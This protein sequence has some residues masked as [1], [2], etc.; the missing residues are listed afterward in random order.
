VSACC[1]VGWLVGW[2]FVV[3]LDGCL[4]SG[5]VNVCCL[6]GWVSVC[7]LSG[8]VF[9]CMG[10]CFTCLDRWVF[11]WLSGCLFG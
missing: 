2:A 4:L 5:W 3:C 8:W 10:E 9:V 1:L 7:C 11:V 6:F